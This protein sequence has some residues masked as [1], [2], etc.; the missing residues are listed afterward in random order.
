[1]EGI[2][3]NT[4][5][6]RDPNKHKFIGDLTKEHDL[7]FIALS[8]TGWSDFGPRFLKKL[9]I[10][11][12]YLWHS[13]APVGR[14]GGMLLEIDLHFYDIGAIDEG[15]FYIK[16]HLCNKADNYKW[17]LALVYGPAQSEH[18]EWF[19]AKLV[20]TCSH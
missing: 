11:R 9:C 6:L 15:E 5:G 18:K 20:N 1:M 8:E 3:W 17:A 4:N 16:F 10:G 14:S 12:D 2:F 13:K 7:N 19:L